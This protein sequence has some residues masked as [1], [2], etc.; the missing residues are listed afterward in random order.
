VVSETCSERISSMRCGTIFSYIVYPP[1]TTIY[2]TSGNDTYLLQHFCVFATQSVAIGRFFRSDI[3]SDTSLS[4]GNLVRKAGVFSQESRGCS[5]KAS[6]EASLIHQ[7]TLPKSGIM[8][9][10]IFP[11]CHT[12]T[13]DSAVTRNWIGL[14]TITHTPERAT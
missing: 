14:S 5:V 1:I 7:V 12:S 4:P 10:Q 6:R 9:T 8:S 3:H 11:S 13:R 2:K